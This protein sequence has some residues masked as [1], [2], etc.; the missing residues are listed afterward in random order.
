MATITLTVRSPDTEQVAP[1][2]R[3]ST[4]DP[5]RLR[6]LEGQALTSEAVP[7]I[8]QSIF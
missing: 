8:P 2:R 5:A 3:V 6:L 1:H 7:S 4:Q